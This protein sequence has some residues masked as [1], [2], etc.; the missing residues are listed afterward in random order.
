MND[1]SYNFDSNIA[2]VKGQGKVNWISV[3][4]GSILV[5][6]IISNFLEDEASEANLA[7]IYLGDGKTKIDLEYSMIHK[8]RRSIS[9]IETNGVLM[10]TCKE[11]L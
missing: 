5:V 8:G 2:F 10:D 1:K 11:S 9:N 4:L 6:L 7:S 3:E